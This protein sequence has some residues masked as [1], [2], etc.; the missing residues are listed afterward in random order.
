M[1]IATGT[2]SGSVAS[3]RATSTCRVCQSLP[4]KL[5][6]TKSPAAARFAD[7]LDRPL[8]TEREAAV[9][10]GECLLERVEHLPRSAPK[11]DIDVLGRA[12]SQPQ[13]KLH[14]R[15]A[16]D[17][18]ARFVVGADRFEGAGERHQRKPAPCPLVRNAV[19]ASVIAGEALEMATPARRL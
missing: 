4:A 19:R 9:G 5:T 3:G 13:P 12:G 18:E 8:A 7:V 10:L 6:C 1:P 15:T 2:S 16:L 17:Q 14:R 11:D